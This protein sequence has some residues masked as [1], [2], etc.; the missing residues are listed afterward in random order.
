MFADRCKLGIDFAE[1][2]DKAKI[3]GGSVAAALIELWNAAN[4]D[5]LTPH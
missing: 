5:L 4:A 1:T 3:L 2:S